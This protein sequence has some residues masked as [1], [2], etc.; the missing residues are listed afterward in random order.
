MKNTYRL[1]G[2]SCN[3]CKKNAENAL[4]IHEAVSSAI[5]NIELSE[6]V[7]TTTGSISILELQQALDNKGLHYKISIPPKNYQTTKNPSPQKNASAKAYN[8]NS[9]FYCP[10]YCEGEKTYKKNCACPVCGMDL[11]GTYPSNNEEIKIHQELINKLKIAIVFTIPIFIIAMADMFEKNP[12]TNVLSQ[13]QWNWIQFTLSL[14][15]VFYACLILFEKAWKSIIT[16]N[17]NMFTLVGLGAGTAFIFSVFGLFF[18]N[19]FPEQFKTESGNVFVYFEATSVILTF[20]LMGQ[21]LEAR[22]HS[23]TSGAIKAL[24]ELTPTKANLINENNA[25]TLIDV[26]NIK[27][28]NKLRVKPGDKIPVDGIILEGN[29]NIDESMIT[30]ESMPVDK[31]IGDKVSAGTLNTN[32]S[33]VMEAKKIGSETL[34]AQI[35]KMV[36]DASRSRAPIQKVVDKISKYFVPIVI[37]ISL[38]TFTFWYSFGPEPK[39]VYA[40]AN[41][42][43]V[44]II[45]CPCALG[46]ATPMS[47]M[48]GIGKGAQNGILI[49]DA[50]AL[51]NLNKIDIL[52]T[53]KTGTL[54]QGKPSV[55]KIVSIQINNNLLLQYI[56]SLNQNS[57]HPLA[58]TTVEY[59]HKNNVKL[60]PVIG[61]ESIAGKGVTGRVDNKKIVVGNKKIMTDFNIIISTEIQKKIIAAQQ[62]DKT[63]SYV[64]IDGKIAGYIVIYD[65]IKD[66][67]KKAIE[68]LQ[69]QGLEVIML[70]GDN[71]YTAQSVASQLNVKN[72]SANCM[73]EDKLNMIVELQKKGKIVAMV[74]DGIND[75][76]ALVQADIG[77]AMAAGTDVA[78]NNSDVT[79]VKSDL[80]DIVN[81]MKIGEQTMINIRQ[82]L[83]FAFIYNTVGLPIAAGALYPFFNILLSPMIAAAA[84]SF[85]SV[86]VI[87][88]SLRMKKIPLED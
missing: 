87:Y 85:S 55:K 62:T 13:L 29:C 45:A 82:N 80:M 63:V 34:L 74:G 36:N 32:R 25:D 43:S 20:V 23:K 88:N 83:F 72:F 33:F 86:S 54:T 31:I 67:S 16:W 52:I 50:E 48:V 1:T 14:P 60:L 5:A 6:V 8:S 10:M 30:G 58:Q 47:I 46:L 51:E 44:L 84:M 49:R 37:L 65:A 68:V 11:L 38:I 61:F 3:G 70:T 22:A 64:A 53:D 39:I 15:I 75:A 78:I 69:K 42:I 26:E 76:P 18:P 66:N 4:K 7:I 27:K 79:L 19:I 56:A 9:V 41:A 28:G 59:A 71:E 21:I 57:E 12:L 35:I 73:P 81:T 2:M 77:I 40:F 17:L 24:L